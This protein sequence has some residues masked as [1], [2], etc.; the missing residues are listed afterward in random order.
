LG[1][2]GITVS[3]RGYT[4][5][6]YKE[7]KT[8][9]GGAVAATLGHVLVMH[10]DPLGVHDVE[11]ADRAATHRRQRSYAWPDYATLGDGSIST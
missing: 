1:D 5:T 3:H 2:S 11:R 10:F 8:H 6:A 4:V 7:L 9:D